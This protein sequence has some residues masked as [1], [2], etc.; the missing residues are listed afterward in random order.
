MYLPSA[1][2]MGWPAPFL[3]GCMLVGP[4]ISCSGTKASSS[5]PPAVGMRQMPERPDDPVH[6][7]VA[8]SRRCT[9]RRGGQDRTVFRM[10][11]QR[12]SAQSV[13]HDTGDGLKFKAVLFVCQRGMELLRDESGCDCDKGFI[14]EVAVRNFDEGWA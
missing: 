8:N 11:G 9:I 13:E 12:V 7:D 1:D 14:N 3:V 5:S 6:R 2:S 4:H 10:Q